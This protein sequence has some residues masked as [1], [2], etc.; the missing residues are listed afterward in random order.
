MDLWKLFADWLMLI[1]LLMLAM[2]LFLIAAAGDCRRKIWEVEDLSKMLSL[3]NVLVN[4]K[5][6]NCCNKVVDVG[7]AMGPKLL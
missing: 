3:H 5:A 1:L 6:T 7:V 2:L 4:K